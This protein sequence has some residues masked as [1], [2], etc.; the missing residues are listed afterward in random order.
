M[1]NAN[2]THV[3]SHRVDWECKLVTVA[4]SLKFS[5][6]QTP[7]LQAIVRKV[8]HF[9]LRRSLILQGFIE[10]NVLYTNLTLELYKHLKIISRLAYIPYDAVPFSNE[11]ICNSWVNFFETLTGLVKLI[12]EFI[13]DTLFTSSSLVCTLLSFN[14]FP[15]KLWAQTSH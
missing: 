2:D 12:F 6:W 4:V 9:E 8:V 15:R 13:L 1:F 14:L 7:Y 11:L 3:V 10:F 5:N